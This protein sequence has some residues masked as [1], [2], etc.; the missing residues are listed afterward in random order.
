MR[1]LL[2]RNNEINIPLNAEGAESSS[3]VTPRPDIRGLTLVLSPDDPLA[4]STVEF[5]AELYQTYLADHVSYKRLRSLA[6]AM[7]SRQ[8]G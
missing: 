1:R 7:R 3:P 2:S 6:Q 5:Y 4:P 8:K